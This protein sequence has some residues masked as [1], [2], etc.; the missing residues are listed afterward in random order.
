[1]KKEANRL[2]L[3]AENEVGVRID[4][5]VLTKGTF[6]LSRIFNQLFFEWIPTDPIV[7]LS[8]EK[9]P[10]N[11]HLVFRLCEVVEISKLSQ[12]LNHISLSFILE[13]SSKLP[14]FHFLSSHA[15]ASVAHLLTFLFSKD[16]LEKA[17]RKT[18]YVNLNY[19]PF[20]EVLK[21]VI[22][23]N[24]LIFL[25]E[26]IKLMK[27]YGKQDIVRNNPITIEECKSRM[28]DF[29]SLK[30]DIGLRGLTDDSRWFIWPYLLGLFDAVKPYDDNAALL[31]EKNCEYT[32]ILNTFKTTLLEE[33]T[34]EVDAAT[35][36]TA[37]I[38]KDVKRTDRSIR[39]FNDDKSPNLDMLNNILIVYALYNRDTGFVQGMGDLVAQFITMYVNEW[40]KN[41][42]GEYTFELIDGRKL[43]Q[44]DTECFIFHLFCAFMSVT[45]QD[46]MFT[47]LIKQ[48][49]FA[50]ERIF[51]IIEEF[52][53]PLADWLQQN[54]LDNMI[55]M[56]RQLIL[57]FKREFSPELVRRLWDSIIAHSQPWT[58][59]R[60][61]CAALL[62][63]SFPR[64]LETNGS[65]EEVMHI[66]DKAIAECD[67][68][69]CIGLADKFSK[70]KNIDCATDPLPSTDKYKKFKPK[71]L[72]F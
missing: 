58:Q 26:H 56:Y 34:K 11:F 21:N 23:P 46:R 12:T 63:V 5:S 60:F 4:P 6:M 2:I 43:N 54:K 19:T 67:V 8:K 40:T 51:A 28:N 25:T 61:F 10:D 38:M 31:N 41:E 57:L 69:E 33:Q 47:D 70:L 18:Y 9:P 32:E 7:I 22:S 3:F 53:K 71:F 42:N 15:L 65:M 13:D 20:R 17:E 44:R 37:D 72:N 36:L 16:I 55:F 1:M 62:I 66:I 39:H 45:Q 27:S 59:L 29:S 68:E 50:F 14:T 52:H 30:K 64:L 49:E 48:Q 24:Q 35:R